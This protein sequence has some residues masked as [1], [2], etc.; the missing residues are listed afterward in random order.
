[1]VVQF[2]EAYAQYE[3]KHDS[4]KFMKVVSQRNDGLSPASP[5]TN[6]STMSAG[7]CSKTSTSM[8]RHIVPQQADKPVQNLKNE[9]NEA[10]TSAGFV[11]GDNDDTDEDEEAMVST[12]ERAIETINKYTPTNTSGAMKDMLS[13]GGRLRQ[14]H[15][16]QNQYAASQQSINNSMSSV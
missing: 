4:K 10:R 16:N 13:P 7:D 5:G 1:M 6:Q 2:P 12:N 14:S 3:Y 15:T 9:N 11:I 8:F